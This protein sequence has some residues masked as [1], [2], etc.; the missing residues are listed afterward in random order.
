[1]ELARQLSPMMY[2][3][4]GLPPVLAIHGDADPTVP[5]DQSVRLAKALKAAG[6]DAELITVP[7]GKHGFPPE[8]M[9]KLWPQIFKWLKKHKITS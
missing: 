4:K 8:D 2:L 6:D 3:R 5:Y 9:N 1:M 7:G